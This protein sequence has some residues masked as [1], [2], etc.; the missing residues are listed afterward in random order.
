MRVFRQASSRSHGGVCGWG[1]G[2]GSGAGRAGPRG[3]STSPGGRVGSICTSRVR[4]VWGISPRDGGRGRRGEGWR[5]GQA[6]SCPSRW[7]WCW[8]GGAAPSGLLGRASAS[9]PR[10]SEFPYAPG[11]AVR[12]VGGQA[13]HSPKLGPGVL[14]TGED[15]SLSPGL[16]PGTPAPSP[17]QS[18]QTARTPVPVR[19]FG[20]GLRSPVPSSP[21]AK[22][23]LQSPVHLSLSEFG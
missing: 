22:P 7:G 12:A 4:L 3:G 1:P 11:R 15:S 20:P 23:G 14:C 9:E 19:A 17:S 6:R 8:R 10:R 2:R 13:T 16:W 18:W 5:G 21:S